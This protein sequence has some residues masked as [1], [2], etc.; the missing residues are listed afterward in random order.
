M[1]LK[2]LSQ[3]GRARIG[4][5]QCFAVILILINVFL[6]KMKKPVAYLWEITSSGRLCISRPILSLW[7]FESIFC[8][9]TSTFSHFWNPGF[10]AAKNR[11]VARFFVFLGWSGRRESNPRIQLGKLMFY[12]WTTP[13]KCLYYTALPSKSQE[14]VRKNLGRIFPAEPPFSRRFEPRVSPSSISNKIYQNF[15]KTSFHFRLFQ[16]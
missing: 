7:G 6:L 14:G 15:K 12:H 11:V 4:N 10:Q 2:L 5:R 1:L 8:W 3:L 16:I 13:A 9:L